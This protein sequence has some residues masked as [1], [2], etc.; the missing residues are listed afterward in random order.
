MVNWNWP[1]VVNGSGASTIASYCGLELPYEPDADYIAGW[2]L[3][4]KN[5]NK[6]LV[7]AAAA[8]QK[9]TDYI[10]NVDRSEYEILEWLGVAIVWVKTVLLL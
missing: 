9:A 8:A 3:R 1:N 7:Q 5:D 2:L 10:L 4:L 6:I